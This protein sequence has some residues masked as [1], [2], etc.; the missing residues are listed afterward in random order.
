MAGVEAGGC[1]VT[2]R[3]LNEARILSSWSSAELACIV[4][5]GMLQ[6]IESGGHGCKESCETDS[7][8]D[9]D[10]LICGLEKSWMDTRADV[11]VTERLAQRGNKEWTRV[12]WERKQTFLQPPCPPFISSQT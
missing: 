1:G 4:L 10:G 5:A 3:L 7:G 6:R 11:E 12:V 9:C 2:E 8:G